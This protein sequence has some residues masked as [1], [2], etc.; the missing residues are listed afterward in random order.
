MLLQLTLREMQFFMQQ[1]SQATNSSRNPSAV[2]FPQK[3]SNFLQV[4]IPHCFFSYIELQLKEKYGPA[5]FTICKSIND[6]IELR[7]AV[8][9]HPG[10]LTS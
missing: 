7:R 9:L 3:V 8:H 6:F 10:L 2:E 5:T 1:Q 4:L